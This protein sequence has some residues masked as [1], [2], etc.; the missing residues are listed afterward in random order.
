MYEAT[1]MGE[2][3][4]QLYLDPLSASMMRTGLRRAV[5]RLVR[6]DGPVTLFGLLH[7]AVTTPDFNSLWAKGSDLEVNSTAW[8]KANAHEEE[9][10]LEKS[11]AEAMIGDVKSAW[12]VEEWMEETTLR[13][14]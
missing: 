14:L 11:Y 9:F 12:M 8:L 7:M 1:T 4:T 5:R 13:D 10:L 3:V 6:E 2:R